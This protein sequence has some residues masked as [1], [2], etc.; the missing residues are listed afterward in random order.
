MEQA[1]IEALRQIYMASAQ[2]VIQTKNITGLPRVPTDDEI[3]SMYNEIN[4]SAAGMRLEY[5]V[6]YVAA[7]LPPE[8]EA[9]E[10]MQ[11]QLSA[12]ARCNDTSVLLQT[13]LEEN[14]VSIHE[15]PVI[16]AQR[17]YED[18]LSGKVNY[19]APGIVMIQKLLDVATAMER[20]TVGASAET[21]TA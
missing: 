10:M 17:V 1:I 9:I 2:E 7:A 18:N 4:A 21:E 5:G 13:W 15:L 20:R 8:R 16:L 3:T 14:N 19:P 12:F 11:K 6:D